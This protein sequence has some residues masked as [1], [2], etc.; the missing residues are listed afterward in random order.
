V[1]WF[2]VIRG[3]GMLLSAA[4]TGLAAPRLDLTRTTKLARATL[5]ISLGLVIGLVVFGSARSL[6]LALAV[7]WMIGVLRSLQEPLYLAWVNHR[8]DSQVRATVISMSSLVDAMGQIGGG[9]LVGVIARLISIP[10]GL[11]SSAALLSPV[12]VLLG[13]QAD[14][15]EENLA[16]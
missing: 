10:A 11:Y 1:L 15:D 3:V 4:A 9:P 2:G 13:K 8:L 12:L 7:F 6:A 5:A 14:K 16:A